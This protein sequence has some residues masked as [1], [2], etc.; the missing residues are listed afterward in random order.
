ML[1]AS[2]NWIFF[3]REIF[4]TTMESKENIWCE[5]RHLVLLVY[6][7]YVDQYCFLLKMWRYLCVKETNEYL[8][9]VT[10]TLET[11]DSII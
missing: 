5:G 4:K 3:E 9:L 11:F 7:Q 10:T 8:T 6:R 2:A 1:I